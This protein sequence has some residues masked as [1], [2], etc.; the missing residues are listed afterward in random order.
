VGNIII[1]LGSQKKWAYDDLLMREAYER[2]TY[3]LK[4]LVLKTV[5]NKAEL[6][7][8][9]WMYKFSKNLAATSRF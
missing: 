3:I 7:I 5:Q 9:P 1:N 2:R 4:I 6:Y 8:P